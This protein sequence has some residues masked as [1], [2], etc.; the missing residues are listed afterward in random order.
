M[1]YYQDI[2]WDADDASEDLIQKAA[3]EGGQLDASDRVAAGSMPMWTVVS[4]KSADAAYDTED[5]SGRLIKATRAGWFRL[6]PTATPQEHREILFP[7]VPIHIAPGQTLFRDGMV[8]C[9]GIATRGFFEPRALPGG[10][11]PAGTNCKMCPMNSFHEAP[12]NPATGEPLD[13]E[14]TCKGGLGVFAYDP[15]DDPQAEAPFQVVFSAS[16]IKPM[17]QMISGQF[18]SKNAKYWAT[19]GGIRT[20]YNAPAD[21]NRSAF[22]TPEYRVTAVLD[23]EQLLVAEGARRKLL[24]VING[25]TLAAPPALPASEGRALSSGQCPSCHAPAGKPHGA[26]CQQAPQKA[27]PDTGDGETRLLQERFVELYVKAKMPPG[28]VKQMEFLSGH[29]GFTAKGY[30]QV[31][32]EGWVSAIADLET[33]LSGDATV[34]FDD[35]FREED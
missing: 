16:S 31:T 9:K 2:D 3:D 15:K 7:M 12:H 26:G 21:A 32:E 5:R 35:P 28:H 6:G 8:A 17:R 14:D 33:M 20:V 10:V 23:A 29:C 34:P 1:S 27:L 19:C 18:E 22:Y 24:D 25:Q 11:M 13:K 4:E 30:S